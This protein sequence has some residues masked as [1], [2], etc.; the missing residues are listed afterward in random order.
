MRSN[1]KTLSSFTLEGIE[2]RRMLSGNVAVAFD[3]QLLDVRGDAL[4][5]Q[6]AINQNLAGA[7]TVVGQNGTLIN[8]LPSVRFANGLSIEKLDIRAEE[9]DDRV[10]INSLRIAGDV[11]ADMGINLAGR[12]T[13]VV[14]NSSI[15]GNLFGYGGF[16]ADTIN[17][18][19][20]TVFGDATIDL[21]EGA[22]RSNAANSTINGSATF[23]GGEGAD[24]FSSNGL[25]VGLELKIE[26]KEGND[27]IN[28][29]NSSASIASIVTDLGADRVTF[30]TFSS[31]QDFVVETGDG[32]DVV[33]LTSVNALGNLSVNLDSGN[34]SLTV[35]SSSAGLDA[36]L[37][38]GAG[39]D[40]LSDQ[41]LTGGTKKEVIEFE[42]LL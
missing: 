10:T 37:K 33:S 38:G 1:R 24:V 4:G 6:F 29:G 42:V 31:A 27:T 20:T 35:A 19:G 26:T 39:V 41:G 30:N 40:T 7:I 5:N 21:A 9:G 36:V 32:N 22:G 14:N 25:T 2:S 28:Y 17:L 15:E 16:D 23:V 11:N 13:F 8:G 18:N 34:D 12:D 3:G